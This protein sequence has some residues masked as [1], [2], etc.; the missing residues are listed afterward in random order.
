M[1]EVSYVCGC[2]SAESPMVAE[3]SAPDAARAKGWEFCAGWYCPAHTPK[4]MALKIE[5]VRIS[6]A[7][8]FALP[9]VDGGQE[10]YERAVMKELNKR[11]GWTIVY[12]H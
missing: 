5:R 6:G 7:E 12:R 4:V 11:D 1:T 2:C 9:K 10:E 8:N 3:P